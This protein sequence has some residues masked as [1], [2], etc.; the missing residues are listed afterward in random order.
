MYR[1]KNARQY[2][3]ALARIED[4]LAQ[5]D[6]EFGLLWSNKLGNELLGLGAAVDQFEL[7]HAEP[8]TD[9]VARS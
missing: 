9:Y 8:R 4:L 5:R 7:T 6:V 2:R 3:E 1:I